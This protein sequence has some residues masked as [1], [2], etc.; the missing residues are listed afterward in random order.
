MGSEDRLG[1]DGKPLMD[2]PEDTGDQPRLTLP[3]DPNVVRPQMATG[4]YSEGQPLPD[5]RDLFRP[6]YR[7]IGR[8]DVSDVISPNRFRRV[9]QSVRVRRN[10]LYTGPV[11]IVF[12]THVGAMMAEEL[13][14]MPSRGPT[15]PANPGQVSA[16]TSRA[17][18]ASGSGGNSGTPTAYNSRTGEYVPGSTTGVPQSYQTGTADYSAASPIATGRQTADRYAH[19]NRLGGA[20][21]KSIDVDNYDDALQGEGTDDALETLG[22]IVRPR[23][24]VRHTVLNITFKY[25]LMEVLGDEP[26]WQA[27]RA[28]ESYQDLQ[29]KIAMQH[30]TESFALMAGSKHDITIPYPVGTSIP[31][32]FDIVNNNPLYAA[33]VNMSVMIYVERGE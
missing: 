20:V 8:I 12:M 16:T 26:W 11:S 1:Y 5:R 10:E 22:E 13:S 23:S 29:R 6:K 2:L 21:G 7:V 14:S 15:N 28:G 19:W 32:S 27:C 3:P 9:Y 25:P 24:W 30:S 31:V 17:G 18:A 33:N 4:G